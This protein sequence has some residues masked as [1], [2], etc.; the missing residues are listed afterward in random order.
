MPFEPTFEVCIRG[1]YNAFTTHLTQTQISS[2]LNDRVWMFVN[3]FYTEPEN[4]E[5]KYLPPGTKIILT[6]PPASDGRLYR[7]EVGSIRTD[8]RTKN[9]V[10]IGA[11]PG[12]CLFLVDESFPFGTMLQPIDLVNMEPVDGS[13]F[14]NMPGLVGG[15]TKPVE[16]S[17]GTTVYMTNQQIL[18]HMEFYNEKIYP[19]K[20]SESDTRYIAASRLNCYVSPSGR[21][22]VNEK[23]LTLH[24]LEQ[25][26]AVPDSPLPLVQATKISFGYDTTAFA[27]YDEVLQI[28][29]HASGPLY[30]KIGDIIVRN[31]DLS[32]T[33]DEID[34][35]LEGAFLNTDSKISLFSLGC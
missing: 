14:R 28:V 15:P 30:A 4:F 16:V 3:G 32:T 24:D 2:R 7:V 33:V 13:F 20:L 12:S 31:G 35:I 5:S 9:E 29:K 34:E 23:L 10:I 19:I 11:R 22:L 25:L 27:Q 1:G 8:L 6:P 18:N 17:N 26:D 21:F